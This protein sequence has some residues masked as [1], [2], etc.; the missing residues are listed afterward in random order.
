MLLPAP[1]PHPAKLCGAAQARCLC[2]PSSGVCVLRAP[3]NAGDGLGAP[4]AEAWGSC[5][6]LWVCSWQSE[7]LGQAELFLA[8]L[9]AP[10]EGWG[11]PRAAR[12]LGHRAPWQRGCSPLPSKRESPKSLPG[13]VA[14]CDGPGS[15]ISLLTLTSCILALFGSGEIFTSLFEM[16][17]P[18]VAPAQGEDGCPRQ[19][20][21]NPK[22]PA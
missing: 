22:C 15:S 10:S 11:S 9:R 16:R 18:L 1:C 4:G 14:G 13:A 2:P 19:S 21:M 12:V 6:T 7:S 5:D 8:A 17:T 3:S 20:R